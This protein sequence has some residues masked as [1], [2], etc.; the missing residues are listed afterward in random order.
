MS[1]GLHIM[2]HGPFGAPTG[3]SLINRRLASGLRARG[4]RVAAMPTDGEPVRLPRPVPPDVYLFH[5]WPF[6]FGHGVGTTNAFFLEWEYRRLPRPWARALDRAFDLVVVPSRAAARVCRESGVTRPVHVCPGGVDPHEFRPDRRP[7]ALPTRKRFRFIHLGG[8]HE[9][10]GTDVLLRAYGA[11][12]TRDDDVCLVLKG[13]HY[14]RHRPWLER[15]MRR[16]GLLR[17]DAPAILYRHAYLPSVAPYFAA[18]DVGVFPMRA[19]C[20]GLPVLECIASGRPVIVPRGTGLDEFCTVRNARFV[21]ATPVERRGKAALEPD[22]EDLRR[23]MRAAYEAG[24]LPA[25]ERRAVA[26]TVA[27]RTWDASLDG[28]ARALERLAARARRATSPAVV[29]GR[30]GSCLRAFL[31]APGAVRLRYGAVAPLPDVL[32]TSARAR[33]RAGAPAPRRAPIERWQD[34]AELALAT[35]VAVTSAASARAFTRAGVRSVHLVQPAVPARA[36]VP[37]RPGRP[38]YLFAAGDP[39]PA[40]IALVLAAWER[41]APGD[42]DLVCVCDPVVWCS[43]RTLRWLVAH[44]RVAVRPIARARLRGE[45]AAAHYLIVP[46]EDPL[47]C[48]VEAIATGRPLIAAAGT[49]A[50]SLVAPGRDGWIFRAGAVA[51]LAAALGESRAAHASHRDR[52]RAAREAGR[53]RRA[54]PDLRTLARMLAERRR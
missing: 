22:V 42:A 53:R 19:E 21:T 32:A 4:H 34:A 26:A 20:L 13:F 52:C 23:L 6:D 40:G 48:F 31:E 9:R 54:A 29:V 18:A 47:D 11:E 2:V 41:A 12:F 25:G 3:F 27:G 7:A 14:E 16:A 8:A 24:P 36:W 17:P 30:A 46:A 38:R 51:G 28:L 33:A 15:E 5:D 10:R 43:Q 49:A 44:P 35:D 39:F 45:I 50:A 1:H 37:P